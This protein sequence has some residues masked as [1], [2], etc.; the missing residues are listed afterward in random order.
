MTIP[1]DLVLYLLL[2]AVTEPGEWALDDLE[3][4]IGRQY[5]RRVLGMAQAEGFRRGWLL[6]NWPL[7]PTTSGAKLYEQ[8]TARHEAEGVRT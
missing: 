2:L 7:M 1:D 8:T 4:D 3:E 5:E 6:P